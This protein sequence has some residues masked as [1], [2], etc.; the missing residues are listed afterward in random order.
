MLLLWKLLNLLFC[1][2]I[3]SCLYLLHFCSSKVFTLIVFI[4]GCLLSCYQSLLLWELIV[5][6]IIVVYFGI[7]V[8]IS[9]ILYT[10]FITY[11]FVRIITNMIIFHQDL[12]LFHNV[13][14]VNLPI[15]LISMEKLIYLLGERLSWSSRKVL[16]IL[17]LNIILSR[18]YFF[19]C[20]WWFRIW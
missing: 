10:W 16:S 2:V 12:P 17:F 9:C 19:T 4:K 8:S 6:I 5:F 7:L 11:I 14:I 13:S 1:I 15:L 18:I 3:L 20:S